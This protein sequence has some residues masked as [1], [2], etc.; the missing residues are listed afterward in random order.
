MTGL[1]RQLSGSE[2]TTLPTN[3]FL[4]LSYGHLYLPNCLSTCFY[5]L[6]QTF[7]FQPPS[8]CVKLK[9]I[10][11]P[12]VCPPMPITFPW[13]FKISWESKK[14]CRF[15]YLYKKTLSPVVMGHILW[16]I[17]ARYSV[18]TANPLKWIRDTNNKY[19]PVPC[20]L[21]SDQHARL[22]LWRSEFES[23]RSIKKLSCKIA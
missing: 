7:V 3:A 19:E 11:C 12:S 17:Q 22:L 14:Q 16:D 23:R 21:S 4:S 8:P 2:A 1:E 5:N 18:G 13:D 10:C 15:F 9:A 20:W 6:A